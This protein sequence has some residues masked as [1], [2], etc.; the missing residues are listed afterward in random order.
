MSKVVF[1]DMRNKRMVPSGIGGYPALV[2]P[3]EGLPTVASSVFH[4]PNHPDFNIA[5]IP[6]DVKKEWD[7][8]TKAHI[9]ALYKWNKQGVNK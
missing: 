6:P 8:N 9:R 4:P 3:T 2:Q 7:E 5:N 1:E